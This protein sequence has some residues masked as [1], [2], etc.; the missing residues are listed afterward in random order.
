[1]CLCVLQA[2]GAKK[3]IEVNDHVEGWAVLEVEEEND[4]RDTTYSDP[5]AVS[6]WGLE[7]GALV[8]LIA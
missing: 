8:R 6:R 3:F 7:A 2:G 1:M 4:D 5:W